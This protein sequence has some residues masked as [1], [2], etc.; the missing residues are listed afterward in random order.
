MNEWA[1]IRELCEPDGQT[2]LYSQFYCRCDVIVNKIVIG[3]EEIMM[4]CVPTER[5]TVAMGYE[6][7]KELSMLQVFDKAYNNSVNYTQ[8]SHSTCFA[9]R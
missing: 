2:S 7:M 8:Y 6:N 9:L 4:K 1:A 3:I 5:S